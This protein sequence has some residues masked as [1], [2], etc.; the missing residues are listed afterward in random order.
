MRSGVYVTVEARAFVCLQSVHPPVC[1]I[2]RQQ[3]RLAAGLLLSAVVAGDQSIAARRRPAGAG[4]QQQM[5]VDNRRGRL[6]T[7]LLKLHYATV[8]CK[9]HIGCTNRQTRITLLPVNFR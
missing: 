9:F 4:T 5:P 1:P 7:D 6:N 8:V 3:W 2:D